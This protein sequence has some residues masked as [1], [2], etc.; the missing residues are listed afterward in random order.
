MKDNTFTGPG[1][2]LRSYW[3]MVQW[4]MVG[5]RSLLPLLIVIQIL[6]GVG[7]V[8][9]LGF[10]ISE[11]NPV[12]AAYLATGAAVI[13]MLLVGLVMIPQAVVQHKTNRTYDFLWSLPIPK[14]CVV[15]AS[16]TV[17]MA[18]TLPGSVLALFAAALR[19][20]IEFNIS[21]WLIPVT[22]LVIL[23]SASIGYAFAHAINNTTLIIILTQVLF[24][25]VLLFSPIH[26]PAEHLPG[27]LA[28]IHDWLPFRHAAELVRATLTKGDIAG[29]GVSI[30]ILSLWAAV[31]WALTAV[32]LGKKR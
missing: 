13:G 31:S 19:Y 27:W 4:E 18:I 9:G 11:I 6:V 32:V 20:G 16:M 12:Q 28:A 21:F 22:L 15:V 10:L 25:F 26:Y 1:Y 5:L 8:T 3:L 29:Q 2:W 7:L 14:A 23:M 17:W 24:F 30:A